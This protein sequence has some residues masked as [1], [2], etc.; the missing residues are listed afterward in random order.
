[1]ESMMLYVLS[2]FCCAADD[3]PMRVGAPRVYHVGRLDEI[4]EQER[5]NGHCGMPDYCDKPEAE[6]QAGVGFNWGRE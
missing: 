3:V 5:E 2:L 1:M 6:D 4:A